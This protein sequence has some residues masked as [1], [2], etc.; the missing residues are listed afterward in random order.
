MNTRKIEKKLIEFCNCNNVDTIQLSIYN[1]GEVANFSNKNCSTSFIYEIASI[2]KLITATAVLIAC[3]E[4]ELTLSTKL[5]SIF[6]KKFKI[7]ESK[8]NIEIHELLIHKSGLPNIPYELLQKMKSCDAN[9][10]SVLQKEMVFNYLI[11]NNDLMIKK[12]CYSNFGYGLLGIIIEELYQCSLDRFLEAKI[13]KPL[14]MYNSSLNKP[15]NPSILIEGFDLNNKITSIWEDNC[16]YGGGAMLSTTSDFILYLSQYFS[17]S[18][19]SKILSPMTIPHSNEMGIGWHRFNYLQ[20][21]LGFK[22]YYW[23]NGLS[24]GYASYTALNKMDKKA[25]VFFANKG[26]KIDN[27][28]LQIITHL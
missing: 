1:N 19:F 9:P 8:K 17:D 20:R 7:H 26:I 10:Y 3:S 6:D 11:S 14:G 5:S 28:A 13:F 15:K 2:T 22:N 12:Y 21:V 27:L 4:S 16:L 23:H 24:G 25:V 18:S